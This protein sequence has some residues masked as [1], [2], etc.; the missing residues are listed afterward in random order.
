MPNILRVLFSYL[1]FNHVHRAIY[2]YDNEE[3]THRIYELLKLMNYDEY[4]DDFI[5]DIRTTVY[6][7]VYSLLYSIES[8]SLHKD[9][10]PRY[11][12]LDLHSYDN[13]EKMFD[14]IS[15]MGLYWFA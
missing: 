10:V 14:K 5:L 8:H 15:H 12:L 7:D 13:Y 4:F 1:K 11:V 6:E 3:S 2:I 9:Q